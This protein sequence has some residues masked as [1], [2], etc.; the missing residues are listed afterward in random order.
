MVKNTEAITEKLSSAPACTSGSSQLPASP[1]PGEP[2]ASHL[3]EYYAHMHTPSF[4]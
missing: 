3:Y 1:D 2:D 4:I